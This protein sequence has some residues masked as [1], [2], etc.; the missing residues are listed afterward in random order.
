M[1]LHL[2]LYKQS[3]YD[4]EVTASSG[5][6]QHVIEPKFVAVKESRGWLIVA[7]VARHRHA[8]PWP[9]TIPLIR[10]HRTPQRLERHSIKAFEMAN[11]LFGS[12]LAI[13][14][15]L[16]GLLLFAALQCLP[17]S[18]P[19]PL[20]PGPPGQ[21]FFGHVRVIPVQNPERYYQKISK[22]YSE[23]LTDHLR[24]VVS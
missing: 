22:A 10:L 1:T 20:P 18:H 13:C 24:W 17:T 21:F 8:V 19:Y 3:K 12:T 9:F 23:Y 14:A 16:L 11:L 6:L 2:A 7:L 5:V 4:I 15:C